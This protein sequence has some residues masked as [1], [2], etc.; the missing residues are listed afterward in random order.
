ML[1]FRIWNLYLRQNRIIWLLMISIMNRWRHIMIIH[2]ELIICPLRTFY[3]RFRWFK[4]LLYQHFAPLLRQ[5]LTGHLKT[6]R[7]LLP[8]IFLSASYLQY[9]LLVTD[10]TF[11]YQD[12]TF[13]LVERTFILKW[14]SILRF[15]IDIK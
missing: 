12:C 1:D 3:L 4:F 7:D 15:I 5:P 14:W 13:V 8:T 11:S 9:L 6:P 10:I 2:L